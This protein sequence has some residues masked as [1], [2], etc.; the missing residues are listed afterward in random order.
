MDHSEQL[1]DKGVLQLNNSFPYVLCA[2]SSG[3]EGVVVS[4]VMRL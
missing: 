4:G 2:F 1:L 3:S